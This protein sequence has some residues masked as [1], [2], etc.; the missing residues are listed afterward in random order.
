MR[1]CGFSVAL[2]RLLFD[3][4][5]AVDSLTDLEDIFI[6]DFIDQSGERHFESLWFFC[7]SACMEAKHFLSARDDDFDFMPGEGS[8]GYWEVTK[9]DYDFIKAN[10]NSRST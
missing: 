9:T 7:G 8:T 2:S 6:T 1:F 3:E 10:D 4:M 5:E